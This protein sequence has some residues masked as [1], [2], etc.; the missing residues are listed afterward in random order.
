MSLAQLVDDSTKLVYNAST[1]T[2]TT[3]ESVKY[4]LDLRH[5]ID[6]LLDRMHLWEPVERSNYYFQD[7]GTIGTAMRPV[8]Y[9]LPEYMGKTSGFN[10]YRQFYNQPKNLRFFDTKS[11][12]TDLYVTFGGNNRAI[13]ETTF[14]RNVN[15]RWNV[16]FDFKRWTVDKQIGRQLS[17]GDLNVLHTSFDLFSDFT[18]KD[19]KYR[20]LASFSRLGHVVN[21]TG[22]II[23]ND[24]LVGGATDLDGFFNYEDAQINL[25]NAV[26][27]QI[28][29]HYFAYHEYKFNDLFTAYHEVNRVN[30][31]NKFDIRN[32]A[33]FS[34]YL[35]APMIRAG[36][37][38]TTRDRN[39][40]SYFENELGIK[41]TQKY[42]DASFYVKR[43]DGV[44]D[45]KFLQR[46][47]RQADNIIGGTAR[48]KPT[49]DL[50]LSGKME[51]FTDGNFLFNAGVNYKYLQG[52]ITQMQYVA[53]FLMDYNLGNHAAWDNTFEP[54]QATQIT[55]RAILPLGNF[56]FEPKVNFNRVNR[57]TY[58]NAEKRPEQASGEAIIFTPGL[59]FKS[60]FWQ[61]L[62]LQGD[63]NYTTIGGQ[64]ADAFRIPE[65]FGTLRL[66]F[67]KE[68][69]PEFILRTG[70]DIHSKSA[71]QVEGYDPLTAQFYLQNDFLA[72]G[73]VFADL[74]LSF[75]VSNAKLYFKMRHLN[76]G[77]PDEGYFTAMHY[78]GTKRAFDLGVQWYF[79]N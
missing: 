52:G 49:K 33:E 25:A 4:N 35:G 39:N 50:S 77:F 58:F 53:P 13:I 31:I 62:H 71:Y 51:V 60:V 37:N 43:R 14:A 17:R 26:G 63:V 27:K 46:K 6:T 64:S 21:E 12:F 10:A 47:D 75:R 45:P 28:V 72:P 24:T 36:A 11:P 3:F 66:F 48:L 9:Q 20:V 61:K 78:S 57:H 74:Y 19:G 8:Y 23:N 42:I 67:Q 15:E 29:Q 2:Y 41:F 18:S 30:E 16:G 59:E 55:G 44:Y 32:P 79:F 56:R 5:A 38:D 22:S 34:D 1:L 68:F 73:Y 7:L 54:I 40:Y 69:N 70:I 76:Q 65:W